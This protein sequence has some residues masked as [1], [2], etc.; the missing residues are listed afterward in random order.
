[1]AKLPPDGICGNFLKVPNAGIRVRAREIA[2]AYSGD[3]GPDPMLAELGHGADLF[4]IEATVRE[5]E[6]QRPVRNLMTSAEASRW[7]R[8][9][10]ARRPRCL[11][12]VSLSTLS[13]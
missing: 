3:T 5:G 13:E 7:A 11:V 1:V 12:G 2:L 8:Q 9:A 4:I 10:G 6:L